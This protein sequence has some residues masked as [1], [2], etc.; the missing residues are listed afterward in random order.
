MKGSQRGFTNNWKIQ[1]VKTSKLSHL[2]Q[3]HRYAYC[4]TLSDR[5]IAAA[6]PTSF[7]I[8]HVNILLGH[9]RLKRSESQLAAQALWDF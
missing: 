9:L 7:P 2:L 5:A 1:S 6:L 3:S 4:R 8:S